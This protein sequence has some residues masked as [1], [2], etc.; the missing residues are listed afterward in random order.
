MLKENDKAGTL[1]QQTSSLVTPSAIGDRLSFAGVYLFTLLLYFRPNELFPGIF[2]GAP[3]IKFV[4]VGTTMIYL[5]SVL[6]QAKPITIWPVEL[7]MTISI[8]LLAV[9]FMPVAA[10][11]QDSMHV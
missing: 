2:G 11:P 10:S 7:N 8:A 6:N 1:F 3:I 4:A 9:A 5:A